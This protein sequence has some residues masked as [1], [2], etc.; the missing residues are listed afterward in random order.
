[1]INDRTAAT[2]TAARLV[3]GDDAANDDAPNARAPR[4]HEHL[5]GGRKAIDAAMR[6]MMNITDEMAATDAKQVMPMR[7]SVGWFSSPSCALIYRCSKYVALHSSKG[8]GIGAKFRQ[9]LEAELYGKEEESFDNKL[10]GSVEE[11]LAICGS[12]DY[13]CLIDAAVTER[14]LQT[15]SLRTYLKEKTDLGTKSCAMRFSLTLDPRASWARCARSTLVC[16]SA[17]WMLLRAIGSDAHILDVLL[18]TWTTALAFFK[19]AAA[20][21]AAVVDRTLELIVEGA[22]GEKLRHGASTPS[23]FQHGAHPQARGRGCGR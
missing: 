2:R 1:M 4:D 15:G 16:E 20:S 6:E 21:P 13:I 14:F 12:R 19:Q 9:W 18:T 7:T 22:R 8:D 5:R 3:R 17:L 10:L 23:S 11:I